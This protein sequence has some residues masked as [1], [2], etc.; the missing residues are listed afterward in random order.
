MNL[1]Q[2]E[3]WDYCNDTAFPAIVIAHDSEE[4]LKMIQRRLPNFSYPNRIEEISLDTPRVI[5]VTE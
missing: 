3:C 1:Y 5:L 2:V 4:A